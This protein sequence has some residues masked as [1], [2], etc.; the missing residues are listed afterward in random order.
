MEF[1]F[2]LILIISVFLISYCLYFYL[3]LTNGFIYIENKLIIDNDNVITYVIIDKDGNKFLLSENNFDK[4]H[5]VNRN[6]V[7]EIQ[8][9]GLNIP[10][11]NLYP[12][13]IWFTARKNINI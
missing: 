10:F 6:M 3:T 7:Y 4:W 11:I 13:I 1:V 8:Y 12:I 9:Y 2:Y 5:L